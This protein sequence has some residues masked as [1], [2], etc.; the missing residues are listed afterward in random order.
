MNILMFEGFEP[1]FDT[2]CKLAP[3]ARAI[4]QADMNR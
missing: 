4:E 1:K 3:R 2:C